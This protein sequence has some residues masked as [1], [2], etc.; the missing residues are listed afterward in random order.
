M[1]ALVISLGKP[2]FLKGV[3]AS[4]FWRSSLSIIPEDCVPSVSMIPGLIALTRIFLEPSSHP[5]DF[6]IES[7]AAF[8]EL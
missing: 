6:V 2:I 4:T 3:L 7:T 5:K 8:V 1:A